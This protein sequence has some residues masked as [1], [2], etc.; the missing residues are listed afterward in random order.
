MTVLVAP[1]NSLWKLRVFLAGGISGCRD[2][3]SQFISLVQE[4]H[5]HVI[6]VNPRRE[7]F[8]V[9]DKTATDIQIEW[10]YKELSMASAV[11]FFFCEET[12]CPIALYELGFQANSNKPL[13]VGYDPN[14]SRSL[15]II[16]QLSLARPDVI[17]HE[18][19]DKTIAAFKTFIVENQ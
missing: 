5:K 7:E 16:K 17:V 2:W 6:F 19:L 15:D 1:H 10:E 3:Q 4:E 8:D 14:Y 12:V 18:G 9:T 11:V 13:I